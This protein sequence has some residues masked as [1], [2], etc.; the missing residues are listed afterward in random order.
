MPIKKHLT[1]LSEK[2]QISRFCSRIIN[3]MH[4]DT[5]HFHITSTKVN[6]SSYSKKSYRKSPTLP[7]LKQ[8][9]KAFLQR[10]LKNNRKNCTPKFHV[11]LNKVRILIDMRASPTEYLQRYM[12]KEYERLTLTKREFKEG[13]SHLRNFD[14]SQLA[15]LLGLL[16]PPSNIHRMRIS[17]HV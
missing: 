16:I 9:K 6:L 3:T 4:G 13:T 1:P 15:T 8:H 12:S 7:F 14:L 2:L 5:A 17:S 10:L 11:C